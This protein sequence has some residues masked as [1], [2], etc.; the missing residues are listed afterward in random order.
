VYAIVRCGGRQEKASV[1][2]VLTVDKLEAEVGSTVTLPAVLVVDEGKVVCE[3]AD[4]GGY[5]VTAEIMGAA[6]GPK[7]N[8]IHFKN[9]TGYRRRQGHRQKYTQVRI[10]DI[11]VVKS[12]KSGSTKT[13]SAG[14]TSAKTGAAKAESA[15]AGAANAEAAKAESAK[16]SAANAEAAKAESAKA[17][18]TKAEAAKAK[19][20][21]TEAA[22][23]DP[24]KTEP[25]KSEVTK[26]GAAK[27]EAAKTEPAKTTRARATSKKES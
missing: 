11:S 23:A 10:T 24:A 25:A 3:S 15:K 7:I 4:L 9:K 6:A 2:D 14:S 13:A 27:T 17:G 22:K 20:A 12:A 8:M 5:Q 16:A 26:R 19:A 18:A 21:E 1:D